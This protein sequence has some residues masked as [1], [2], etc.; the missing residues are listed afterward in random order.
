MIHFALLL[1]V[2]PSYGETRRHRAALTAKP[3][4][5]SLARSLPLPTTIFILLRCQPIA[6]CTGRRP[7]SLSISKVHL[8]IPAITMRRMKEPL[9]CI[10][11]RASLLVVLPTRSRQAAPGGR[12]TLH[13]TVRTSIP[14][15][16]RSKRIRRK[17]AVCERDA[18]LQSTGLL[19]QA[20]QPACAD[21]LFACYSSAAEISALLCTALPAWPP[22]LP[23]SLPA[24]QSA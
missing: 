17:K 9:G 8:R 7:S 2:V 24:C 15:Q 22:V 1:C 13:C 16:L 6:L 4:A 12:Q 10:M 20:K 23:A 21:L 3:L 19:S 14:Q 11:H 18:Y 5:R